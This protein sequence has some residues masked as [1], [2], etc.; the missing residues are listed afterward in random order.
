M[1][2]SVA[3]NTAAEEIL[4]DHFARVDVVASNSRSGEYAGRVKEKISNE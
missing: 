2:Q 3:A 1:L 4:H